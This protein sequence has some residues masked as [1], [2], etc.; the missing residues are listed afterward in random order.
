MP[1]HF[2]RI[3]FFFVFVFLKTTP[4][5]LISTVRIRR[6]FSGKVADDDFF[7]V[8]EAEETLMLLVPKFVYT[9]EVEMVELHATNKEKK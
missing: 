4:H 8:A 2:I 6:H 9:P 1:P 7:L 5:H 3:G